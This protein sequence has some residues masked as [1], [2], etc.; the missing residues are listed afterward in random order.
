MEVYERSF[1]RLVTCV[2]NLLFFINKLVAK[3]SV[4]TSSKCIL[5]T[6]IWKKLI[7]I[8]VPYIEFGGR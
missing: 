8:E 7:G 2:H 1:N 3:K 4:G 5:L 6:N